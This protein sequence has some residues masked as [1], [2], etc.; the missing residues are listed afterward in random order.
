M[1]GSLGSFRPGR[2]VS[3]T[4][5]TPPLPARRTSDTS[6]S[7]KVFYGT[8]TRAYPSQQPDTIRIKLK[9]L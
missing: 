4:L 7:A 1:L 9:T 8:W 5:L 2:D 6:E 3:S